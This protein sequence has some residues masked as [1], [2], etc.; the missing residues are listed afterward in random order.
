MAPS[1]WDAKADR[2]LLLAIIDEGT[3]KSIIWPKVAGILQ[4]KGYTFTH[5]ACRLVHPSASPI[6]LKVVIEIS[7]DLITLVSSQSSR[8]DS[9]SQDQEHQPRS[10]RHLSFLLPFTF[11]ISNSAR[12]LRH[13]DERTSFLPTS[14]IG[15]SPRI[16]DSSSHPRIR[17]PTHPP[18]LLNNQS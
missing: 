2:D 9:R 5:E 12:T 7:L 16:S 14:Q 18:T 17:T 1:Q 10:R 4:S 6:D 15:P 3:L 13:Q 8:L 11:C